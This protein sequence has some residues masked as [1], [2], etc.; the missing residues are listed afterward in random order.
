MG[1]TIRIAAFFLALA[2]FVTPA[3][4]QASTATVSGTIRDQTGAVIPGASVTLTNTA[5]GISAKASANVAG[6]YFF[7]G[8]VPGPYDLVVEASGMQKFDGKLTVQ[9]QQSAVVDAVAEGRAGDHGGVRAGRDPH[10]HHGQPHPGSH[11]GAASASSSCRS[12]AASSTT[13]LLTVPGM[14]QESEYDSVSTRAFGMR[15]GSTEFVL[16]GAATRTG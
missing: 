1:P 12:T 11:A 4:P 5:T 2:V 6:F 7:P 14:E 8:I 9:V 15:R 16:D 13:L 10:A 3:M